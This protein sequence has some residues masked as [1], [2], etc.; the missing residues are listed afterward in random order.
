MNNKKY[1]YAAK[2]FV[3]FLVMVGMYVLQT[4]PGFLSVFGTKPNFVIPAAIC[5]AILE[6]EFVGGI[7]GVLGGILCDFGGFM[8]FGFHSIIMLIAC[9]IAGLL[10]IYLLQPGVI[11][12]VL[13]VFVTMMVRGLLEFL[14][15]FAVWGY[16]HVWMI[17]V[18]NILPG[19]IYTAAVSP[20]I[21]YLYRWLDREF[22]LRVR[23]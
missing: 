2:Y 22:E 3:Y 17:L 5:I 12:Y 14:L 8:L 9:V 15:G 20:L 13:L 19:V 11:N 7:Y 16:E 21:F 4:T 18:Y 10:T 23:T 6:G 1:I